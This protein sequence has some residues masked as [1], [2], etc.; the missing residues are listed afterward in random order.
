M[1]MDTIGIHSWVKWL[2]SSF[3]QL[4]IQWWKR[5]GE[6]ANLARREV[7]GR[8][9]F[10]EVEHDAPG[11][12]MERQTPLLAMGQASIGFFC[13]FT[14]II[15]KLGVKEVKQAETHW[16][17]H[18]PLSL[19]INAASNFS[20]L[21]K[22]SG[23]DIKSVKRHCRIKRLGFHVT[24]LTVNMEIEY[25]C[26]SFPYKSSWHGRLS[27]TA[28]SSQR[29]RITNVHIKIGELIFIQSCVWVWWD[30]ICC[31]ESITTTGW[32]I[33]SKRRTNNLRIL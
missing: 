9:S 28:I 30:W 2:C 13:G 20:T 32:W 24:W 31:Q 4:P 29:P 12:K 18:S 5:V 27:V 11:E 26:Q 19:T 6:R 7:R 10:H 21:D 33:W 3:H 23:T 22:H 16:I 15:K 25:V 14:N 17:L 8:L 1:G